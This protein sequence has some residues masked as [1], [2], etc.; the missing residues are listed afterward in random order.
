MAHCKPNSVVLASTNQNKLDEFRNL[1]MGSPV[2]FFEP[3]DVSFP[4]EVDETGET[5]LANARLKAV[6]CA[7]AF[8]AWS[9]AD[10]SGI[11]VDALSGQPGVRSARFAGPGATDAQRNTKLLA[12]IANVPDSQRSAR[13]RCA[14]AVATPDGSPAYAAVRTIEGAIARKPSGAHGFGFDPVFVVGVCGRTMAELTADAKNQISHRG[15][16]G[17]AARR[18][19][20]RRLA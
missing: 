7:L 18:F 3:D 13:F 19:L 16:A 14:V 12:S 1:F 11:Q 20:E 8:G 9:L 5:F 4:L 6:T 17:R 2:Q 15:R 10:D